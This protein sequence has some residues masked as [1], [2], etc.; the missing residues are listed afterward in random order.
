MKFFINSA[1]TVIFYDQCHLFLRQVIFK[2]VFQS[3]QRQRFFKSL[4]Q[5]LFFYFEKPN[6]LINNFENLYLFIILNY[7]NTRCFFPHNIF[8]FFCLLDNLYFAI[9]CF[10]L[11][12]KPD[13]AIA[14]H[15]QNRPYLKNKINN[16]THSVFPCLFG[17]NM[18]IP[19]LWNIYTL[20]CIKNTFRE[21]WLFQ[22]QQA[23]FRR[24]KTLY[25]WIKYCE[26]SLKR[27]F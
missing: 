3:L 26:K 22:C 5:R 11:I 20:T 14:M 19:V 15:N 24:K 6:K 21:R 13:T 7:F 17:T 9:H 27:L 4:P 16:L 18:L 25:F 2:R 23:E 12:P 1:K 8:S 10:H